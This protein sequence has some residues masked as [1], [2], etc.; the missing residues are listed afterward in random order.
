MVTVMGSAVRLVWMVKMTAS[1][2][3]WTISTSSSPRASRSRQHHNFFHIRLRMAWWCLASCWKLWK[4]LRNTTS[5]TSK[6]FLS[7]VPF[8]KEPT[9]RTRSPV[10]CH[11][12]YQAIPDALYMN[13]PIR[14]SPQP[15]RGGGTNISSLQGRTLRFQ[16]KKS[17]PQGHTLYTAKPGFE[18][19]QPDCSAQAAY[20]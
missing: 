18:P 19:R 11:G 16:E 12:L 4:Q 10:T 8:P 1:G 14:C 6:V 13:C 2:T 5:S 20:L 15:R 17:L 3:P 9:C 7:A